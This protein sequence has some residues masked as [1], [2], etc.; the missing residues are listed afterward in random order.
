MQKRNISSELQIPATREKA[1][2][3]VAVIDTGFDS[4]H[5]RLKPHRWLN[6]GESGWDS[7]GQNKSSNGLDDDG[8]GYVDD[9]TGF[10]F[11][12]R[13]SGVILDTHGHGTHIAGI[14]AE[15][16]PKAQLMN[17][18][19][20]DR[21]I[22]GIAA[23]RNSIEAMKYAIA[24]EA[25]IINYSGGGV[26]PS[27]EEL[28]VLEEASRKG[29]LV[30]AAAGNEGSN[31]ERQPFY[32][33]NYKLT[34][35]LS[36]T[37]IDSLGAA[38]LPTS[39]FGTRSVAVAA[40]G[41]DVLSTLPGNRFGVMTGTSQAT[42]FATAAAANIIIE[43]RNRGE[44]VSPEE[45]IERIV[46]SSRVAPN[47]NGKTRLGSKLEARRALAFRSETKTK[48]A[49][50]EKNQFLK[51]FEAELLRSESQALVNPLANR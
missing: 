1:S 10:D 38:I 7:L 5:R 21:T 18:K 48:K 24:M 50:N 25:D 47:L 49:E 44:E 19:Y 4:Q 9:T 35:I 51:A 23:L 36:V 26:V 34:N 37:A 3:V 30:V 27:R 8:N 45:I 33:A 28:A 29:I 39:N 20:F 46:I 16:A 6:R 12:E 40:P 31:S 32:P 41:K 42:A 11:V 22:D 13:E 14:V 43:S 2:V 15:H 17:L